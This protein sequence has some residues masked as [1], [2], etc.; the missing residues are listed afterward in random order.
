MT[1]LKLLTGP[2]RL[3]FLILAPVCVLLGLGTALWTGGTIDVADLALVL[4]G[5]LAAHVS[6][7][8]LNEYFDFRSGLDAKTSRTPFSGGSGTLQAAPQLA[9]WALGVGVGSSLIL[10]IVG[11]CLLWA[12]GLL[13]LPFGLLGL[14]II[15]A[16]TPLLTRSPILC[17]LS[18][19]LGFGPL[20]VLG[21]H[22]ALTGRLSWSALAVSLVP[23]FLVSN[24]LLLN[25]FPDVAADRSIGRRSL[26]VVYGRRAGAAV[27]GAFHLLASLSITIGVLAGAL[28]TLSLLG[29][30]TLPLALLSVVGALRNGAD[31]KALLPAMGMNVVTNLLTP[32]LVAVGLL[33]R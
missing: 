14:A 20:L 30:A 16:Y 21:S 12:R 23:L 19:G 2:M 11:A 6:V 4:V 29:L 22:F 33:V 25:Q 7:N 28:P 1:S 26:P 32:V 27:Y 15:Y 3:P 5:A 8:A 24:L 10:V 9:G 31:A 17:L 13:F 18:P